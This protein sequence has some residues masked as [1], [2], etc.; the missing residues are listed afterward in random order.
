MTIQ[1]EEIIR[2][3]KGPKDLLH[4]EVQ[5]T[6]TSTNDVIKPLYQQLPDSISLVTA[7]EQTAGRGRRGKPFFSGLQHGLYFSIALQ[8]NTDQMEKIPL[9]TLLTAAALGKTLEKYLDEPL[10]IKWVNDIFYKKRKVSGILSEMVTSVDNKGK[11]GIIIG[12]GLNVAGDFS[13]SDENIQSVAGTIFGREVPAQFNESQFLGEFLSQFL[14]YHLEFENKDFISY[15]SEHL[16]GR[17]K[18]VFYTV[19]GKEKSGVIKGINQQGHLLVELPNGTI[20][21]LYGQE[22]HF[23]SQQFS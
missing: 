12:V 18:K 5:K 19:K 9:Y 22:V 16:L 13:A 2:H 23:G 4:I 21:V 17:G 11:T 7:K 14:L 1:S 3:F 8:P 10:A 15:Y 20:D 6:V